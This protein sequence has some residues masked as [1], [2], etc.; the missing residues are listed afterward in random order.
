MMREQ[1]QPVALARHLRKTMTPQEVKLWNWLRES[2]SPQGFHFR[3][4]V[5]LGSLIVDFAC[6]SARLVIELDGSQHGS[7]KGQ[8]RDSKRDMDLNLLG[9]R[10][11]RFWNYEIDREK[12][13]VMDTIFA[14]L[15]ERHAPSVAFGDTSPASG[16]GSV[17]ER[18]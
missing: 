16:G 12:S 9:Y 4:Q 17:T 14:A 1:R 10:V 2:L 3:R 6:I 5:P 7:P 15:H 11:L 18:P 13:V 8:E